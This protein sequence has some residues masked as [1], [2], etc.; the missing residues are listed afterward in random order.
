MTPTWRRAACE[1]AATARLSASFASTPWASISSSSGPYST[2]VHDWV[3][4]A[5]TPAR[6][7]GTPFPTQGTRVV[8]ATPDSPVAG[9]IAAIEKVWK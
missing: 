4:T 3:A 2:R 5:P 8:T 9:S 7:Q 1:S 6:T